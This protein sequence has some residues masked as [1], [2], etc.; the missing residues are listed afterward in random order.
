MRTLLAGLLGLTLAACTVGSLGDDTTPP[1]GDDTTPP[2]DDGTTPPTPRLDVTVTPPATVTGLELGSTLDFTITATASGGFAGDVTLAANGVPTSW[3]AA[4]APGP[5]ITLAADGTATATMTVT[6]PSDG[7]AIPATVAIDYTSS[8]GSAQ[9]VGASVTVLN[10]FTETVTVNGNGVC[11]YPQQNGAPVA[12][13]NRRKLRAGTTLRIRNGGTI[14]MRIHVS[15]GVDG[16]S[17]QGNAMAANATY[18]SVVTGGT[19][20]E[21]YCHQDPGTATDPGDPHPYVQLQ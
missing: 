1:P 7:E 4:F 11:I 14:P 8:L 17:H 6:I 19:S 16:F 18:D 5:T 13:N 20:A 3:L 10:Q 2:G 21:W 15:D 12:V 9:A